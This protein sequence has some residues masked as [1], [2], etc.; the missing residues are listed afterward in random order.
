MFGRTFGYPVSLGNGNIPSISG[1]KQ[2]ANAWAETFGVRQAALGGAEYHAIYH[3]ASSFEERIK[4][5]S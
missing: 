5:G 3:Q 2:A 4:A 1:S